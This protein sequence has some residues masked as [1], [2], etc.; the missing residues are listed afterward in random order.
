MPDTTPE[1]TAKSKKSNVRR[2]T[3]NLEYIRGSSEMSIITIKSIEAHVAVYFAPVSFRIYESSPLAA[4]KWLVAAAKVADA[5][6]VC[7][8]RL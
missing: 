2:L 5:R 8:K 7:S 6:I 4:L 1:A 3:I